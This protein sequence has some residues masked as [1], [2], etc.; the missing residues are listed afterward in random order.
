MNGG[1]PGSY[2]EKL[3]VVFFT[4][5][6]MVFSWCHQ[7][8]KICLMGGKKNCTCSFHGKNWILILLLSV[9][10]WRE[11]H[12]MNHVLQMPVS[13][14]QEKYLLLHPLVVLA[15]KSLTWNLAHGKNRGI[16]NLQSELDMTWSGQIELIPWPV[17]CFFSVPNVEAVI[18][19]LPFLL[20]THGLMARSAS[21]FVKLFL[22]IYQNITSNRVIPWPQTL[23]PCA[24]RANVFWG[25]ITWVSVALF[26]VD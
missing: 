24:G 25:S 17:R 5:G 20:I 10:F 16:A 19:R 4:S 26:V 2:H 8:W 22:K 15:G 18:Q 1:D 14:D 12:H 13:S 11:F 3:C 7:K 6:T 21:Q 23:K 9:F